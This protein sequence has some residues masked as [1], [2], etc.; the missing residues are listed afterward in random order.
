MLGTALSIRKIFCCFLEISSPNLSPFKSIRP[1]GGN[2][3]A[4][5]FFPLT[6]LQVLPQKTSEPD[7]TCVPCLRKRSWVS[8]A[9]PLPSAPVCAGDTSA[10]RL[11]NRSGSRHPL[12]LCWDHPG[13]RPPHAPARET[14]LSFPTEQPEYVAVV[15]NW[16]KRRKIKSTILMTSQCFIHC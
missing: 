3:Q 4:Y 11:R 9:V 15:S 5:C 14:P 8:H 12:R 16:G 6:T 2:K 1:L 13:P 7:T 10:V